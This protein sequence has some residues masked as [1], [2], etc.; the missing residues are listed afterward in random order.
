MH[1]QVLDSSQAYHS[2]FVDRL[3]EMFHL[4][5]CFKSSLKDL[6]HALCWWCFVCF[7]SNRVR[8]PALNFASLEKWLSL[9]SLSKHD[10]YSC[11]SLNA[12]NG[13]HDRPICSFSQSSNWLHFLLAIIQ[14]KLQFPFSAAKSLFWK[15]LIFLWFFWY[16]EWFGIFWLG[17]FSFLGR[18]RGFVFWVCVV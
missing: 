1:N 10:A 17:C 18:E 8:L 2:I 9:D 11:V 3:V 13:W 7:Q 14:L 4:L 5:N 16:G 15:Q 12:L 6:M